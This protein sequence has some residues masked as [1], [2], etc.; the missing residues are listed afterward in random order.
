MLLDEMGKLPV[1]QL[2]RLLNW[3]SANDP[4]VEK[5]AWQKLAAGLRNRWDA[6]PD[7]QV[8][9]QFGGMLAGVLQ[10]HIGRGALARHSSARSSKARRKSIAPAMPGSFSMP[11]SASPGNRPTRTRPSGCSRRLP[12]PIRGVAAAGDR[13]RRPL[14]NDR[15]E[16][17]M[18]A[19][20]TA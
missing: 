9:N 15:F 14:P 10:G 17:C 3:I 4:A 6:E 8:K 5:E 16:W 20:R 19:S 18:P 2:Q 11:C 7:W 12:P 13:S 1:D